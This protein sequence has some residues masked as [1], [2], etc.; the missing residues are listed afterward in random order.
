MLK[1][2][3]IVTA[4][5]GSILLTGCV[6][7]DSQTGERKDPLEGFNRS[8][9]NVNY[10][11]IDPYVLKPVATGWKNYIPSP[12]RTGIVNV[13]NNLD[14]PVSFVNRLIEGEGQKAAVHFNRFWINSI[15]GLGG[16]IDWA[17]F[18]KRLQI[19]GERTF[20]DTLASYGV[21]QGIYIMLPAYGATTPTQLTGDVVDTAYMYP[22]WNWVGGPWSLVKWGVQGIDSRAKAMDKEALLEQAQDPYVAFREAYYQNLEFRATDGKGT[23]AKETLSQD[24]LKDID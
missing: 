19:D 5:L 7:I 11:Y 10:N 18:D 23:E 2:K 4:L 15:F 17:S 9:W 14:E 1:N 22:F 24:E 16:L 13:A 3:L 21:E 6:T 20:G 8:M 12:V